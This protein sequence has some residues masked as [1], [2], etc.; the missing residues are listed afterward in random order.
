M[1]HVDRKYIGSDVYWLH[2]RTA[3]H[4]L[5]SLS[6]HQF[7]VLSHITW[8]CSLLVACELFCLIDYSFDCLLN[9]LVLLKVRFILIITYLWWTLTLHHVVLETCTVIVWVWSLLFHKHLW[10][11]WNP[12]AAIDVKLNKIT[13]H[14]GLRLIT[15][16]QVLLA[17]VLKFELRVTSLSWVLL[18][19]W[20]AKVLG[21]N[22]GWV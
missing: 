14:L 17:W 5:L 12:W 19:N 7:T 6:C 2:S 10:L 13:I 20:L 9:K 8:V 3:C 16:W 22:V 15:H 18:S 4:L 1:V 11:V 21:W